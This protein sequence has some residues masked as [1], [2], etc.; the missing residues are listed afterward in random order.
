MLLLLGTLGHGAML[1]T[2]I[3]LI[4]CYLWAIFDIGQINIGQFC[5]ILY[6]ERHINKFKLYG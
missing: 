1:F 2:K 5:L 4:L 6:E 3:D